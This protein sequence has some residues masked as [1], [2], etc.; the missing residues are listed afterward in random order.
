MIFDQ[1]ELYSSNGA[2][3]PPSE[4]I[5]EP[6]S[7]IGMA[8]PGGGGSDGSAST[9]GAHPA[10]QEEIG[11]WQALKE[12]MVPVQKAKAQ[13]V[14]DRE[15]KAKETA[16]YLK[17]MKDGV[18]FSLGLEGEQRDAFVQIYK[19]K[20]DGMDPGLGEAFASVVASPET[21]GSISEWAKESDTLKRAIQAGGIAGA[22][23]L[24]TSP[25]A[26]K[27][28]QAEIDTKRMPILLRKGQTFLTGWQQLVPPEMA[29][30]INKDGRI[31]ASE[32]IAANEWVKTN[33]PEMAKT[34]AFTDRDLEVV[35]RN[36][37]AFYHSL[38]I[39]SPKDEGALLVDK[40]KQGNKATPTPSRSVKKNV[41]GKVMDQLQEWD[42]AKWVDKGEATPHHKP[43]APGGDVT[44]PV[45]DME[46]KVG[47]DYAR[48]SKKFSERRPLFDSSTD[49]FAKRAE[50]KT[51]AGDAALMYAYAKMR[52]PT[53]RLAVSETKDLKKLGNIFE[54]FGVSV[55]AILDKGETLPDRVAKEMYD[56]IRRAFTE[57][58]RAQ[59]KI[60]K[61]YGDK[62]K[63]YGGNPDRVVN[64]HA[65]PEE[66]LNPKDG[67]KAGEPSQAD[68]EH[69]A[70]KHG[71]TV[72]E[73]K[74]RLKARKK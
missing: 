42:G 46:L 59:L 19:Q 32:L 65:V 27:T 74:R 69:T 64:R 5:E 58:N 37:D 6:G 18:D 34:L 70:K 44:K 16:A 66:E 35:A 15:N 4:L 43:D 61:Q 39:V 68:L 50:N 7:G 2:S 71:I 60:E 72:E 25:E 52:D 55:A 11:L 56:E 62:V 3:A 45:M 23:K 1:D 67:G 17:A 63:S 9:G 36:S 48:D 20:L 26:M 53:D 49:Y 13:R 29:E 41:G 57:Q 22:K 12:T 54:R 31:S 14:L 51:S 24:L 40:A 73:V 47:D 33:N 28:I 10:A 38:G 30:N 21:A 8:Q